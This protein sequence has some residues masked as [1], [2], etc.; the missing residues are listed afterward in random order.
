MKPTSPAT[1]GSHMGDF[2]SDCKRQ[3]VAAAGELFAVHAV[4]SRPECERSP[5]PGRSRPPQ[6][7]GR[8]QRS[9]L[10]RSRHIPLLAAIALGALLLAAAAFAATQIIGV[11]APVR[12]SLE[13]ERSS[14]TTGVGVPVTGATSTP[15]SAQLLA[16]SVPDPAGGLP[17]GM[18]IVR[19]TRGLECIQIGR[20]LDG[21]LGILGQDGEFDDDRLFHEL[22]VSVLEPD[23]C[24]E[25]SQRVIMGDGGVPAAGAL[26]RPTTSCRLTWQRPWPSSPSPCPVGDQRSLAFGLLGPHAVSVSYMAQGRLQTVATAGRYGA[27]LIVLR[28]AP[29][30]AHN[31]PALGGVSGPI[32]GFPIGAGGSDVIS[33]LVFRFGNRLCQTGFNRQRGGPPQCTA[34]LARTPTFVPEI[35]HGLHTHVAVSMRKAA[36][37][38]ALEIAFRAPAPVFNASTAYDVEY[39][40]PHTHACGIPGGYGQSIERDL[41]R[42]QIVH[43]DISVIQ[44]SG[45]H[46]VAQGKVTLGPQAFAHGGFDRGAETIARF[47]FT[48]P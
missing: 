4:R 21:R 46:G 2:H 36:G 33:R 28:A 11:G 41:A 30:P 12:A 35:P 20:L 45:C 10:G 37:G 5:Q 22:P 47:S 42:G 44:P 6:E 18:R 43:A 39:T 27:Y 48:L 16:I 40:L 26:Q 23:T 32:G 34:A 1:G 25:P 7:L 31:V 8:P 13:R 14:P 15:T 9:R 17:W 29:E 3:L 19:T 38:Y 24:I